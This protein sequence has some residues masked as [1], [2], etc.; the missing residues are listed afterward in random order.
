[1]NT[2]QSYDSWQKYISHRDESPRAKALAMHKLYQ[3]GMT[4]DAIASL[5]G[6]HRSRIGQIFKRYELP[7]RPTGKQRK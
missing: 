4:Y 6:V 1:M 5:Y 3:D 7:V 2:M